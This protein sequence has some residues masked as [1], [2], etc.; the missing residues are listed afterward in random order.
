MPKLPKVKRARRPLTIEAGRRALD[1]AS[2]PREIRDVAKMAELARKW[3]KHQGDALDQQI[4]WGEL[5]FDALRKLGQILGPLLTRHRPQKGDKGISPGRL[6]DLARPIIAGPEGL[7]GI[8]N[9]VQ[10]VHR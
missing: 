8:G 9:G 4:A 7:R 2:T 1:A 6:R 5:R 3:A 10:T